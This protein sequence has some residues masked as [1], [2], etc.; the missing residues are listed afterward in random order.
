MMW[1]RA[2]LGLP[3]VGQTVL[4]YGFFAPDGRSEVRLERIEYLYHAHPYWSH[5]D[6]VTHWCY[7][8]DV[9]TPEEE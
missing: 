3:P 9:P 4:T 5:S 2:G 7:V 1:H 8:S 6:I